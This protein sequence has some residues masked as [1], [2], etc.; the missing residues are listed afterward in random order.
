M[1]LSTAI[2][3]CKGKEPMP[4][5]I[6]YA[7]LAAWL[8]ELKNRRTLGA[9]AICDLEFPLLKENEMER[10]RF[11]GKYVERNAVPVV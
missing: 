4:P 9:A 5:D 10:D 1:N 7:Q 2:D 11:I 8:Q 6:D 3:Y